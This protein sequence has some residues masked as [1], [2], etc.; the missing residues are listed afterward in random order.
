[1]FFP[2]NFRYKNENYIHKIRDN[3]SDMVSHNVQVWEACVQGPNRNTCSNTTFLQ[4]AC[5]RFPIIASKIVR[6]RLNLTRQLLEDPSLPDL[7]ILY[8]VRDPRATMNSRL[9][10]VK[11]CSSSPDCINAGRLCNDLH[12]DLDAFEALSQ[13]YPSRVALIKY[14]TL[15]NMPQMTFRAIFDFAGLTF[16]RRIQELVLR[17]TSR[18]EEQPWST[19]RKSSER[20]NLWKAKLSKEKIADIQLVCASVLARLGYQLV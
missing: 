19:V 9:S 8:L 5:N 11:W 7:K 14:E 18:N 1:M 3:M 15:A 20:V 16:T 6:L 10:S 17:H 12:S 4:Q 13:V 2:T